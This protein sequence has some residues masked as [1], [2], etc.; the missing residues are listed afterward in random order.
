MRRHLYLY[1]G[2]TAVA[3]GVIGI[4]LP[5]VPTVP[6]LVLAA[7]CFGKS[8]PVWEERLLLHPRFGPHIRAWRERRAIARTGKWGATMAFAGSIALTLWLTPWPWPLVTVGIAVVTLSW[9]W[10]RPDA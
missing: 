9:L 4:A 7:W 2:I 3:L 10:T 8:N 6:F 1:A 5:I